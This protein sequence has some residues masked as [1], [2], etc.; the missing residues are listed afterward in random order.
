MWG[1]KKVVP[2]NI[3]ERRMRMNDAL[4]QKKV[5][6]SGYKYRFICE[7]LGISNEGLLKKRK[8]K[9][10][11]KVNEINTITE[12]LNLTATERDDIFGLE[13]PKNNGL[14]D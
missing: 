5:K 6:D 14:N 8:G 4:L 11:Y 1:T 7:K 12:L 2:L 10:P 13:S 3:E 9:I